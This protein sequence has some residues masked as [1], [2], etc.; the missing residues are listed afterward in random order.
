MNFS[1]SLSVAKPH[2]RVVTEKK[3]SDIGETIRGRDDGQRALLQLDLFTILERI[4]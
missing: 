2:S 3:L 1:V 4:R